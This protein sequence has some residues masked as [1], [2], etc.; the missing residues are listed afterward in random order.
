MSVDKLKDVFD[1]GADTWFNDRTVV[2]GPKAPKDAMAS[3]MAKQQEVQHDF[4]SDESPE[5]VQPVFLSVNTKPSIRE[6]AAQIGA[7]VPPLPAGHNRVDIAGVIERTE[8]ILDRPELPKFFAKS[9]QD[10]EIAALE[11]K[12]AEAK[13]AKRRQI[14]EQERRAER[15]AQMRLSAIRRGTIWEPGELVSA[16]DQTANLSAAL[17]LLSIYMPQDQFESNPVVQRIVKQVW[18]E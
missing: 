2:S 4:D 8:P 14:E 9:S 12:L 18:P 16:P 10:D 13:V 6:L 15:D 17:A 5:P 11:K 1:H 7:K 3:G